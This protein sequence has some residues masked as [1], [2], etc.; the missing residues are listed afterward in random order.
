VTENESS[1]TFFHPALDSR[2]VITSEMLSREHLFWKIDYAS[3]EP[4]QKHHI[5]LCLLLAEPCSKLA[6]AGPALTSQTQRYLCHPTAILRVSL[7]QPR[8]GP[9]R[10]QAA[11]CPQIQC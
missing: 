8:T 6:V 11:L 10:E 5:S 7:L 2:D 9:G 1:G 4:S 3:K